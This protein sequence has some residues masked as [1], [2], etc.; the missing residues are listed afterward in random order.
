MKEIDEQLSDECR[1]AVDELTQIL[2]AEGLNSGHLEVLCI[3]HP[4]CEKTLREVFNTWEKLGELKVPAQVPDS[5]ERFY[6]MLSDF[7]QEESG[8]KGNR[9]PSMIL[10]VMKWAA[11]LLIGIFIGAFASGYIKGG[12]TTNLAFNERPAILT[13]LESESSMERLTAL[14]TIKAI[15]SPEDQVFEAMFQTLTNDPNVNVRL[16]TVEAMLHFADQPKARAMLI[17]ALTF[18]DSPIVQ[19]TL[20]EVIIKLQEEGAIEE[21]KKALRTD[22]FDREVKMHIEETLSTL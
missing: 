3:R 17:R 18:Q 7:E 8:T 2:N 19:L 20:A 11:V 15:D 6:R 14:Q 21:L 16:S 22:Q 9:E 4:Q 12:Y 13:S 5:K 10:S 1:K